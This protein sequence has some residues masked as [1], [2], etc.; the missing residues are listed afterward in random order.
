MDELVYPWLSATVEQLNAY[1]EADRMPHGILISGSEGLGKKTLTL[2]FA[3]RLLCDTESNIETACDHCQSCLLVNAGNHP[4]FY[5]LQPAESGKQIL[6]DDIRQLNQNL[7]LQPQYNQ[8]RVV[9]ICLAEQLNT[10]AANSFL[11]TLEEP[12]QRTIFLLVSNTPSAVSATILSRCQHVR[13]PMPSLES[14]TEWLEEAQHIENA[15]ALAAFSGAAPLYAV[16]LMD[17]QEYEHKLTVLKLFDETQFKEIPAMSITE[18]W[19]NYS[20]E[21]VIYILITGT[22]D[23]I[24]LAMI[25]GI[26]VSALYHPD[27]K[28]Q[29]SNTAALLPIQSLFNF[30]AQVYRA[31]QLLATQVNLQL[32]YESCFIQWRSMLDSE[33]VVTHE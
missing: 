28:K 19:V 22:L 5:L 16:Q 15:Y 23:M 18:T 21:F 3:K 7:K 26:H 30:L 10:S 14:V 11:K 32:V 31:K 4:D 2:S 25:P 1:I 27:Q 9:V 29:L 24:R 13:I 17:N 8:Y 12:G 20:A 33:K 6:V